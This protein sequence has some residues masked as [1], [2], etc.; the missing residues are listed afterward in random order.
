M[1]DTCEAAGMRAVC[2][3]GDTCQ[4]S[5]SRCQVV[6]FERSVCGANASMTGLAKEVCGEEK[7]P[8]DCPQLD[9]LF[10]YMN[11]WEGG[12][13]GVVDGQQCVNGSNYISGKH[14]VYYAYC[15]TKT[16]N[17]A[18]TITGMNFY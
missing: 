6:V 8:T 4:Y 17:T 12:E 10:V 13:C 15:V 5:S 1:A 3:G 9:G 11:G 18:P 2:P 16:R 7:L 14:A